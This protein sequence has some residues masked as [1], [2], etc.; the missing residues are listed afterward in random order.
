[1]TWNGRPR[2][3][4]LELKRS[5]LFKCNSNENK[6][7]HQMASHH[8]NQ[9]KME[10]RRKTKKIKRNKNIKEKIEIITMILMKKINNFLIN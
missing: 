10:I 2:M 1:L 7:V 6:D 3:K 4:Q 8:L 9:T 5:K